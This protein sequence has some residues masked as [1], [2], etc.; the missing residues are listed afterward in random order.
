MFRIRDILIWILGPAHWIMDSDL[1]LVQDPALFV[2]GCQEPTKNK[3][4]CNLP[5]VG[6]FTTVFKENKS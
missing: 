3:F 5:P 1:D 6:T 4:F 2:S